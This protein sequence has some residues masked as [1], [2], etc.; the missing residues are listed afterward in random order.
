MY[1]RSDLERVGGIMRQQLRAGEGEGTT[2]NRR[3]KKTLRHVLVGTGNNR[4]RE[5]SP[6][7]PGNK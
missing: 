6:V 5:C 3:V 1:L 4:E 7:S 2:L